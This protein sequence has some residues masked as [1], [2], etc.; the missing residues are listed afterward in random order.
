MKPPQ[1]KTNALII[2]PRFNVGDATH[3]PYWYTL[4]DEA[5]KQLD[6]AMLFESGADPLKH[7]SN[8]TSIRTQRFQSKPLNLIERFFLLV[9]YVSKGYT[10]LYIH[11][12]YWSVVLV[13]LAKHSLFRSKQVTIYYWDCEKYETK[14]NN[15]ML[16]IALKLTDVLV[17]GHEVIAASYR[18][19]FNFTKPIKIVPNWV[20]K[21]RSSGFGVRGLGLES[22]INK[23]FVS[24]SAKSS[25]LRTLHFAHVN[26]L[27]VHHIS[28]RKGS[29]ELPEI[30]KQTLEKI[31]NAYFHIVGEGPDREWLQVRCAEFGIIDSVTFYGSLSHE[32]T[33]EFYKTADVFIMPS[34]SEGFPRVILEAMIHC[35]PIVSTDV[36]CVRELFGPHQRQF[37]CKPS[38]FPE[39]IMQLLT[40]S[41]LETIAQENKALA[42]EYNLSKASASYISLFSHGR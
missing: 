8:I 20:E 26:I 15:I 32:Q 21:V 18:S 29:R 33:A 25:A 7:F 12:S 39:K 16:E 17:T 5:G 10:N 24:Q 6:L 11:Y 42:R 35:L 41:D 27:F 3:Y 30:I 9:E 1:S 2:F 19:V 14:P 31:P 34:R 22:P 28:P 36:G 4:F 38:Q 40:R 37:L 13:W 23:K